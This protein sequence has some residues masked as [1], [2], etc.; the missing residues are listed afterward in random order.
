M[1]TIRTRKSCPKNISCPSLY[2]Y[3]AET[4]SSTCRPSPAHAHNSASSTF[5][6]SCDPLRQQQQQQQQQV[7]VRKGRVASAGD[8]TDSEFGGDVIQSYAGSQQQFCSYGTISSGV[9][10]PLD[11]ARSL[12]H[13]PWTLEQD[14]T[15]RRLKGTKGFYSARNRRRAT[16]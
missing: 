2:N 12:S 13:R 1:L 15:L 9:R 8:V 14:S 16:N 5:S 4:S 10:R 11:V 7:Y 3:E 6:L